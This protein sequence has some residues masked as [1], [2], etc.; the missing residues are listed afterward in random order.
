MLI[1]FAFCLFISA[2]LL[3]WI[4]PLFGKMILPMLGGTPS[5]WNTCMVFF[6]AFLLFGYVYAHMSIKYLGVKRQALIHS[7]LIL[8]PLL[9]LPVCIPKGW[10]PP[11]DVNP[12]P[13]LLLLMLVSLGLPFF[14]ISSSAP[15]LQK[16]FSSTKHRAA[17]DP[18]FLY[19]ASNLGSL[20]I[21]IGYP[22]FIEPNLTLLEQ[23][24]WWQYFYYLFLILTISCALIVMRF[25]KDE[26][27]EQISDEK[28]IEK[29]NFNQKIK[30]FLLSFVPSSLML[31]VTSYVSTDVSPVPLIWIIPLALYL[32]TFIIVFSTRPILKHEHMVKAMPFI[33][34]FSFLYIVCKSYPIW[35]IFFLHLFQFVIK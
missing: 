19:A 14:V 6:Q 35:F 9:L 16:W 22:V 32:L 31:G 13:W 18:Y 11:E 24:K 15:M 20:L 10:I 34:L 12:I 33:V 25:S 23:S 21:L 5:V 27:S 4:E 28:D 8:L 2:V 26:M 1:L 30:W 29:I 7:G 3:F 17:K